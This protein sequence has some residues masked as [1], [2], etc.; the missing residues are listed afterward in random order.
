M[1]CLLATVVVLLAVV[2][3]IAL[4]QDEEGVNLCDAP[5]ISLI[6]DKFCGGANCIVG[7]STNEQVG[8][9]SPQ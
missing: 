1:R 2:A 6:Y 5:C 4:A 8:G 9:L 3:H 7:A